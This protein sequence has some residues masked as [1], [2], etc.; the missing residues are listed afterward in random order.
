MILPLAA[1]GLRFLQVLGQP[2]V[3]QAAHHRTP[4]GTAHT[5]PGDRRPGVEDG[6]R[7]HT[8]D[9]L[10]GGGHPHQHRLGRQNAPQRLLVGRGDRL[11]Q[12]RLAQF[13]QAGGDLLVPAGNRL[14]VYVDGAFALF[15]QVLVKRL[16]SEIHH[17]KL[18]F[19]QLVDFA[20]LFL[21]PLQ[22]R[23]DALGETSGLGIGGQNDG[24]RVGQLHP[25]AGQALGVCF[26][27]AD[28]GHYRQITPL[29]GRQRLGAAGWP[30]TNPAP[31]PHESRNR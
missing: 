3:D 12:R 4:D 13:A 16:D 2:L 20:H 1:Q 28:R 9:R 10:P 18:A 30:Q 8:G 23:Q 24:A 27:T 17:R 7:G 15:D 31:G 5:L 22:M 29:L 6:G 26:R 25:G 14:P 11:A 19:K 21:P